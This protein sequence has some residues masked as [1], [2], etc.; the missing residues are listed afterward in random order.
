[1]PDIPLQSN[2]E[3]EISQT[4]LTDHWV[5]TSTGAIFRAIVFRHKKCYDIY[6][7]YLQKNNDLRIKDGRKF[8]KRAYFK[9]P[10]ETG[11]SDYGIVFY[12]NTL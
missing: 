1:M 11:D 4:H 7:A 12:W 2:H 10:D 9:D 6:Y 8:N 3:K 5:G